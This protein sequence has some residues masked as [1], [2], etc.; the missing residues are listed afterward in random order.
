[1][2]HCGQV[3]PDILFAGIPV[4]D[5][6]AAMA[7]YHRLFG[8][9]ADV[10][11]QPNDVMWQVAD[12]GWTY[13]VRDPARAGQALV[14]VAGPDF[15]K[16]LANMATRGFSATPV[17]VLGNIRRKASVTD[18]EGNRTT[19]VEVAN[20]G[21]L[22]TLATA[23]GQHGNARRQPTGHPGVAYR[24]SDHHGPAMRQRLGDAVTSQECDHTAASRES[25][26]TR[27][28]ANR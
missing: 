22:A 20:A 10:V 26:V 27:G 5:F 3:T 16:T 15:D 13:L 12:A 11:A 2:W 24:Q 1:M 25:V 8:R 18:P 14:T 9:L 6:D 7:W 19:F 21:R 23:T 17:A 4:S 28:A